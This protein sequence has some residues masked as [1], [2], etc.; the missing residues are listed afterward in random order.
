[1]L[2]E[3]RFDLGDALLQ[4]GIEPG[5]MELEQFPKL[6]SVGDIHGVEPLHQLV[7]HR[8]TELVVELLGEFGGDRREV[9]QVRRSQ[10]ATYARLGEE[11]KSAVCIEVRL[12]ECNGRV[13]LGVYLPVGAS[14]RPIATLSGE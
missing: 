14:L 5:E 8:V 10:S 2:L 12:R 11:R 1:M 4:L 3:I 13:R 6:G 7:G 9:L